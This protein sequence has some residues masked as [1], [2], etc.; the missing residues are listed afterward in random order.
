MLSVSLC[1]GQ[2]CKLMGNCELPSVYTYLKA[3]NPPENCLYG[4]N[5]IRGET[6]VDTIFSEVV[7]SFKYRLRY[8][9]FLTR[10]HTW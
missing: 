2:C 4:R 8:L 1:D 7:E 10:R 6:H 9:N 3:V 5:G